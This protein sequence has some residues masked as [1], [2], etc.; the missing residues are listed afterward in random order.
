MNDDYY[1][2]VIGSGD[3]FHSGAKFH[4]SYF[5]HTP[6]HNFLIDCGATT[7]LGLKKL[8]ISTNNIDT[9]IIS[10]FH[11]DHF[12][13]LPF[14]LLEMNKLEQR[15]KPLQIVVPKSEKNKIRHLFTLLYPGAEDTLDKLDI[16]YLNF[17]KQVFIGDIIIESFAVNHAPNISCFGLSIADKKKKLAFSGDTE[18]CENLIPLA[19]DSNLFLCECNFYDQNIKGHL[20]YVQIKNNVSLIK[21]EKIILTHAGNSMLERKNIDL[22]IASDGDIYFI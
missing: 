17:E 8:N 10:H 4:T 19:K 9:I 2:Q 3:A 20:N 12:G 22:E 7:L 6:N 14:L 21:S 13:G 16:T 18:W 11:G 15:N 5:Y 1:L